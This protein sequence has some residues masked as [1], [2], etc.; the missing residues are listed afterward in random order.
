MDNIQT[1]RTAPIL[2]EVT[3]LRDR[4][5]GGHRFQRGV[6][7]TITFDDG[8]DPRLAALRDDPVLKLVERS[9][10]DPEPAADPAPSVPAPAPSADLAPADFAPF[11]PAPAEPAPSEKPAEA[12]A[13]DAAIRNALEALGPDGLTATGRPSPAAVGKALGYEVS[14]DEVRRATAEP[15]RD[16]SEDDGPPHTA[17]PES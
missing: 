16:G 11:E 7:Q 10:A 6:K 12:E 15:N 17:I 13:L 8:N 1:T 9:G 14:A 4:R 5:R 3:A 2:V